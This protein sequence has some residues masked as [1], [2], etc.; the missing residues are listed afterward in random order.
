VQLARQAIHRITSWFPAPLFLTSRNGAADEERARI[1]ERMIEMEYLLDLERGAAIA[2]LALNDAEAAGVPYG[3]ALGSASLGVICDT[4]GAFGW[5]EAYHRRAFAAASLTGQP[6]L[7]AIAHSGIAYHHQYI[8]KWTQALE[9]YRQA[10]GILWHSGELRLWAITRIWAT[11]LTCWRGDLST[12][13]AQI[14]EVVQATRDGGDTVAQAWGEGFQGFLLAFS[15]DLDGGIRA[16]ESA[17]EFLDR[18][19]DYQGAT[20]VRG[21]LARCYVRQ[22]AVQ[23]AQEVIDTALVCIDQHKVRGVSCTSVRVADAEAS[24]LKAELAS[25]GNRQA[26][27]DLARH[28]CRRALVAGKLDCAGLPAAYR[29]EG[30]Y[31]WLK[32]KPTAARK[33][34]Q[35][36]LDAAERLGARYETGLTLLEMGRRLGQRSDLEQ[37][38]VLL[39]TCGADFDRRRAHELLACRHLP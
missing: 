17:V 31:E 26:S 29:L 7:L 21:S 36:S 37:A 15:G 19:P 22:G 6:R 18:V 33:S 10:A 5:A 12:A 28:A 4:V 27:L 38:E 23:Q 16:Q 2:L 11:F 25:N 3:I 1:Y 20:G 8:G 9:G 24:L 39:A 34:W 14:Q 32:G 13:S 30:V 35:R